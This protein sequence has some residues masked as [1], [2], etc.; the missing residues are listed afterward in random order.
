MPLPKALVFDIGDVLYSWDPPPSETTNIP[1]KMLSAMITGPIWADHETGKFNEATCFA[2]LA[3]AFNRTFAEVNLE[4]AMIRN[5]F[6]LNQDL[7][8]LLQSLETNPNVQGLYVMSNI[9]QEMFTYLK[10]R[11][12]GM[13]WSLFRD[14]FI[15]GEAGSRKPNAA[16]YQHVLRKVGLPAERLFFV[17][18]KSK[19]VDAAR[20][21][22]IQAAVYTGLGKLEC[23]I[24]EFLR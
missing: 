10:S 20:A 4:F 17:D 21:L 9:S 23:D 1:P 24:R 18:D 12:D 19:N 7:A 22:G 13:D 6:R 5:G 2:K 16:F 11:D 14:T 15:S 8:D 3:D